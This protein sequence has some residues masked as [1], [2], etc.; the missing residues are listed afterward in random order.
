MT[1]IPR[2]DPR[3]EWILRN[4]LH[5]QYDEVVAVNSG[6]V[7]GPT[8]LLRRNP[9]AV[10][11]IGP[12]GIKRIDRSA[13]LTGGA[14]GLSIRAKGRSAQAEVELPLHRVEQPEFY[15]AVVVDLAGGRLGGHDK[16]VLGQA[17]QLV[18]ATE[19]EGAVVAVA[20]G[21]A[22]EATFDTA[23]AD[24]LVHLTEVH[25]QPLTGYC[26]EQKLAVL[27]AVEAELAPRYWLFPD[28]VHGGADLGSRLAARLGERPAVH[29]WQMDAERTICRGGSQL[30]DWHR[31]TARVTL[32]AEE[33]ALPIDE[34]R[35]EAKPIEL[36]SIPRITPR[37]EDLGQVEV[38]PSKIALGEAEFILS[39]G[40]G[41]RDWNQFH[42]VAT[43]L[44][45]TEGASR[46]AVDDGNMPRFRQVGATG[47]WVTARVYVA[48]G[49][50]GA[51]QHMQGIGQC[52]KVVAINLDDGCDMIKRA[53]LSVIGDSQGILAELLRLARARQSGTIPEPHEAAPESEEE[54]RHVA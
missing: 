44:G 30:T 12:N 42:E 22:R 34:T 7:R 49:I 51:I 8:G 18:K 45:A 1:D 32:L 28:S 36:A 53:D 26:P 25:G 37:I 48:V 5:P 9:H 29:A 21:E 11:F 17:H 39:A 52:D 16:D 38:D 54:T 46:V 13:G 43:A 3:T 10:G 2:R 19:G 35:H 40:N 31:P 47:T 33:C 20:L 4:R 27:E 24:R 23:G 6:P 14:G 15:V 41:V 50:S